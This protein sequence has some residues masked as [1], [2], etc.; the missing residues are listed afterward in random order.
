MSKTLSLMLDKG[1]VSRN[2]NGF[3]GYFGFPELGTRF[4]MQAYDEEFNGIMD[5]GLDIHHLTLDLESTNISIECVLAD[6]RIIYTP[7]T[8]AIPSD[9]NDIKLLCAYLW[10]CSRNLGGNGA[11]CDKEWYH[12]GYENELLLP[13]EQKRIK[14]EEK[15]RRIEKSAYKC[16]VEPGYGH[17]FRDKL[18]SLIREAYLAAMEHVSE[19]SCD[20]YYFP[21]LRTEIKKLFTNG[22]SD[23]ARNVFSRYELRFRYENPI[24]IATIFI[25]NIS[26][27]TKVLA[28]SSRE[29]D[30][31]FIVDVFDFLAVTPNISGDLRIS[32]YDYKENG[33]YV[34]R[35]GDTIFKTLKTFDF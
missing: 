31:E 33:E 32:F 7:R 16:V 6:G 13:W 15:Y 35:F 12:I 11:T 34:M 20:L 1:I 21:R 29:W 26:L 3:I 10:Y 4:R 28:N 22:R 27:Q 8:Y 14:D 17:A 9:I 18:Y 25:G 30:R 24:L 23:A 5:L 2:T 19:N